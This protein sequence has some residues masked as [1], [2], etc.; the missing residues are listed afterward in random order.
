[1]AT[2]KDFA[3][4]LSDYAFFETHA[5]E[6]ER[7]AAAYAGQ[8]ARLI[9]DGRTLRVLDFGCGTGTFTERLLR[10][11]RIP[12]ERLELT[13]TEPVTASHQLAAERLKGFTRQPIEHGD[14][15]AAIS[16]REFD[17]IVSNH[18]LY[19]VPDLPGTLTALSQRLARGGQMLLAIAGND[20][21]LIQF[22]RAGF[23]MI[24]ERVPYHVAEDVASALDKA[25]ISYEEARVPYELTFDDTKAN[26]LTIL[27]FLFAE[28]L[29]QMP[30]AKML[31]LFDPF[32]SGGRIDIRTASRHFACGG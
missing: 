4:I 12:P 21:P 28:H 14:S 23:A 31:A 26:R 24:G 16:R 10:L 20:N 1:M 18:V 22:W 3:P 9:A 6:A 32:A 15:L 8:I 7:D 5:T 29:Q 19:Y 11:V 13:I 2:S 30:Q 25:G 17:L 27:R